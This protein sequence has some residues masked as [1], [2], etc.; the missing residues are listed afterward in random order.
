MRYSIKLLHATLLLFVFL[1]GILAQSAQA[2]VFTPTG[3]SGDPYAYTV[4]ITIVKDTKT[5]FYVGMEDGGGGVST[6]SWS[7]STSQPWLT[8]DKTSG[9]NA[10]SY[11]LKAS[12]DATGLTSGNYSGTIAIQTT[13]D[14]APANA[15]FTVN[16]TVLDTLGQ[17][18]TMSPST[19]SP[20][21]SAGG[22][23][24][25]YA[26]TLQAASAFSW[27]AS[28]DVNWLSLKDGYSSSNYNSD[29]VNLYTVAVTVNPKNLTKGDYIGHLYFNTD[30][31]T[32]RQLT[33]TVKLTVAAIS[34]YPSD[35]SP[36]VPAG[37]NPDYTLSL[38]SNANFSWTAYADV[39]WL[40]L[41]PYSGTG[42][43]NYSPVLTVNTTNME[44]GSYS[45]HIYFNTDVGEQRVLTVNLTVLDR[46]TVTLY[47][48]SIAPVIPLGGSRTY[49][50]SLT[51]HDNF[52]WAGTTDVSWLTLNPYSDNNQ[53]TY[54]PVLTV[55]VTGLGIGNYVGHVIFNTNSRSTPQLSLEVRLTVSRPQKA[56][57]LAINPNH[58]FYAVEEG[59]Y[60]RVSIH[61][62]DS[63]ANASFNWSV[64]ADSS[65]LQVLSGPYQAPSDL[66]FL[67]D[68]KSL[69]FIPPNVINI[70]PASPP[71][72]LP[73][74]ICYGDDRCYEAHLNF[75]SD[76]GNLDVPVC[77]KLYSA[78]VIGNI[79]TE[80]ITLSTSSWMA[81][82]YEMEKNLSIPGR[83][84]VLVEHKQL[85]PNQVWAYRVDANGENRLDLFSR[86]GRYT[87]N[88]WDLSY[89]PDARSLSTVN[90]GGFRL[91][92]VEGDAVVRVM[93]GTSLNDLVE[94]KRWD[95]TIRPLTGEWEISDL[96]NG[97]WYKYPDLLLFSERY[98]TLQAQWGGVPISI[99]YGQSVQQK[100]IPWISFC[101]NTSG[102]WLCYNG[103]PMAGNA[104]Y[105][106]FITR[107]TVGGPMEFRYNITQIDGNTITGEWQY[108]WVGAQSWSL[109][110]R[111]EMRA[112]GGLVIPFDATRN[113][114]YVNGTVKGRNNVEYPVRFQ[115][116]TGAA[117]VLLDK[118]MAE[119]LGIDLTNPEDPGYKAAR[120]QPG[121][122]VGVGGTVSVTY[123]TVSNITLDGK[124]SK[125]NVEVGFGD[126]PQPALLGMTFLEGFSVTINSADK[127]MNIGP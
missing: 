49:N 46:G 81:L 127:S 9:Q 89:A 117:F 95:I 26:V 51:S 65:W 120:C 100:D 110:E 35:I 19:L 103:V 54:T 108:R 12:I 31:D 60:K 102:Q 66:S 2:V 85:L 114:Y 98:G 15:N 121:S 39:T 3:G 33:L 68:G 47:P 88:A 1:M 75:T 11:M 96:F 27:S 7:A 28:T 107:N 113:A 14:T 42:S 82:S 61:V 111:F 5:F 24:A 101:P 18:I 116:D 97:K 79:D 58:P 86:F 80:N 99:G 112:H 41:N 36:H 77:V 122:G 123:C 94:L 20:Q 90:F 57:Q 21:M 50:L 63:V 13:D 118:N 104:D 52:T 29:P 72:P 8:L 73:D 30:T 56:G 16:L 92:G 53:N 43:S 25:D 125:N 76:L 44:P 34:L 105:E 62:F 124:V 87:N 45:G 119:Y 6:F 38:T 70:D 22:N 115:V 91:I 64:R 106:F 55:N 84:F 10:A 32:G 40:T 48:S 126:W 67:I 109:P 17:T 23:P 37:T 69:P 71:D 74:C 4:N 93:A 78:G 59:Q 83:V